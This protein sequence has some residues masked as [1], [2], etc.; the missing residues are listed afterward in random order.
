M[1]QLLPRVGE[2]EL[3]LHLGKRDDHDGA[4]E[5]RHQLHAGD[6]DDRNA[7]H[8]RRQRRVGWSVDPE[9]PP[10]ADMGRQPTERDF[11]VIS[12]AERAVAFWGRVAAV[13]V[14][15]VLDYGGVARGYRPVVRDQV[16]LLPPDMREWLA[17]DHPVWMVISII[18]RCD[19][20]AF[21]AGRRTGGVG[22]QGYD[23][24]MLVTLLV[25]AWLQGIRSSRRIERG[26][27]DVVSYRVIC[28][29]QVPDHVTIA[30][31]RAEN[32]RGCAALFTQVLMLAAELGLGR[33]ETVALDGVKIASNASLSANRS[34]AAARRAAARIAE[35]AVT[36]HAAGDAAEDVMFGPSGS[37]TVPTELSDPAALTARL[38][39]AT[40]ALQDEDH[41][42]DDPPAPP[43]SPA[44]VTAAGPVAQD[45]R[46]RLTEALAQIDAAAAAA[47][48]AAVVARRATVQPFL[49]RLGAGERFHGPV[50]TAAR[51]AL[52]EQRLAEKIADCEAKHQR[53]QA[54]RGKASPGRRPVPIEANVK[55]AELRAALGKARAVQDAAGG[56]I[57]VE[58]QTVNLTD[59]QSRIQPVRGGGW[60]Q[61]YNCQAVTTADGLIVATGVGTS[62]VD[63]RYYRDMVER[64]VTAAQVITDHQPSQDPDLATP[65]EIAMVLAD[66]GYCTNENLTAPG[67]DRLI[68]T[69]K[70]R[71]IHHAATENP[72]QGPP[73]PD[74]D[75]IATMAHRLRTP[76]GITHYAQ[77]S[78]IAETPFGHAKHNLGFRRFTS[79]GLTR[80]RSEW[81]FHAA[82]HNISKIIN[83]L[84]GTPLPA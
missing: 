82:V 2:I 72:A 67:P 54:N 42:D 23:P 37:M 21:H 69:G 28:G 5:R 44:E 57:D 30:R 8:V 35:Q 7:Q 71:D 3:G 1:T 74:A 27:S 24:D 78:H 79:R 22:R 9:E 32:H 80:A 75:P 63:H 16:F 40:S 39:A 47:A 17:P 38:D 62:P 11:G 20:S 68:A 26:C 59:P 83:H 50:P 13:L 56:A 33:L 51:V 43:L 55:I 12:R 81:H 25:W 49:G 61:G 48:Q 64:A 29:G 10:T 52:L 34:V 84:A 41:D 60:L 46:T 73:P 77:R 53:W 66:A 31:F 58:T 19:T 18:D 15:A 36:A 76:Q 45:R 70:A 4:V 14:N 6:R 65:S